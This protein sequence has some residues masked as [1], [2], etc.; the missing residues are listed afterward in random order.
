MEYHNF[1][2]TNYYQKPSVDYAETLDQ[3][4]SIAEQIK[5]MVADIVPLLHG[6]REKWRQSA[7]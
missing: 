1:T 5:P 7:L 6:L 3:C 4:A 2:L